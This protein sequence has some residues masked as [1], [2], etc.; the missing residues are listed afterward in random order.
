MSVVLTLCLCSGAGSSAA[1]M[2]TSYACQDTRLDLRCPAG[3]VIKV[4]TKI[5]LLQKIFVLS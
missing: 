4:G 5:L 2:K 1:Q 3:E